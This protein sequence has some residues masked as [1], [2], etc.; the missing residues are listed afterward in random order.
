MNPGR[1]RFL[2]SV[3]AVAVA[4]AFPLPGG[5]NPCAEILTQLYPYGTVTGRWSAATPMIQN[6]PVSTWWRTQRAFER[7]TRTLRRIAEETNYAEAELRFLADE[8]SK[9]DMEFIQVDLP[10]RDS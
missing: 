4:A 3:P 8:L 2:L 6:I 5:S 10:S 9:A 7:A 1:R